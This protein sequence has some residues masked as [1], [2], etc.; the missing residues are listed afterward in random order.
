MMNMPEVKLGSRKQRLLPD[1]PVRVKK[2][3]SGS[4]L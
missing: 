4:S 2:K 1:H 3:S